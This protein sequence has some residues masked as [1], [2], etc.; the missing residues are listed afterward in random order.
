[1][2]TLDQGMSRRDRRRQAT[3]GALTE[4]TRDLVAVEGPGVSVQALADRA[5]VALTTLYN[6]FESKEA[7]LRSTAV[8]SMHDFEADVNERISSL[9][10][11]GERVCMRTRLYLRM[12]STH[13]ETALFLSRL[14]PEITATSELHSEIAEQEVCQA[15]AA[16]Q[17]QGT[18]LS[19]AHLIVNATASRFI[20]ISL[21]SPEPCDESADTVTRALMAV[22]GMPKQTISRLMRKSL[23]T[24]RD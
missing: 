20:A 5:D 15:V 8:Q 1:M 2:S 13:R 6:H 23:P 22:L 12:S 9:V 3:I 14:S 10:D 17:L 16:G 7:L 18:D 11:P 21:A 24:T 4:A 19:V